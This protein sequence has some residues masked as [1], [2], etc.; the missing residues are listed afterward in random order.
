MC[1]R[2]LFSQYRCVAYVRCVPAHTLNMHPRALSH[3]HAGTCVRTET[4]TRA[5]YFHDSDPSRFRS[6]PSS[7]VSAHQD[8]KDEGERRV[9]QRPV[10]DRVDWDVAASDTDVLP[11][12]LDVSAALASMPRSSY[13]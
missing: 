13:R 10:A 4:H 12:I 5:K 6:P 7:E 8:L 2:L 1:P 9:F 11:G 3:A